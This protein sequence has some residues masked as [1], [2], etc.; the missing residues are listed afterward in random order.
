MRHIKEE[1]Y[2]SKRSRQEM[3]KEMKD[4]GRKEYIQYWNGRVKETIETN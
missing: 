4:K 3:I 2:Q 1:M